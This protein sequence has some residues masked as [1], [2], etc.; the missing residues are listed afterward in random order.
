MKQI[1]DYIPG[2]NQFTDKSQEQIQKTKTLIN[3]D[4]KKRTI[5]V[6]PKD[7][8]LRAATTFDWRPFGV[9]TSVKQQGSC[10][11]CWS[12]AAAG[13]AE[14]KLIKQKRFDNSIDLSEQFILSCT[15]ESNCG[16]GYL[17]YSMKTALNVPL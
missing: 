2:V 4:S 17:E 3:L 5:R 13:A 12:F 16:G 10:G 9:V 15:Q 8:K 11:G 1:T 7:N 6:P 14:S